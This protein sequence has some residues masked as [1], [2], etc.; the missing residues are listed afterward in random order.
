LRTTIIGPELKE[1]GDGLFLWVFKQQHIGRIAAYDKS[2]WGGVT[3][4]ELAKAIQQCIVNNITGL[5]Q[6]TNGEKISKYDLIKIIIDRFKLDISLQKDSSVISDKSIMPSC[7][8]GFSY[9]VP[10]YNLMIE[11]LYEFMENHSDIYKRYLK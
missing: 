7:R 5:F 3:T 8:N 2:I 9:I 10:A 6:L 4:L 1:N 11:E